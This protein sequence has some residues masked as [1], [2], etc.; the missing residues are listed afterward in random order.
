MD[1][2]VQL[3]M[4]KWPNVPHCYGWLGLDARGGWRMRDERSQELNLLGSKITNVALRD[5]INRNYQADNKG[6]YFFQNGPQRVYVELQST[7]Y[8]A[9]SDPELGWVL[10]TGVKLETC[11][12]IWMIEEGNLVLQSGAVLA[13]IDDRDLSEALSCVYLNNRKASD[14]QLLN[15]SQNAQSLHPDSLSF[16]FEKRKTRLALTNLADLA[17]QY[18][19]VTHPVSYNAMV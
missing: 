1:K 18:A 3:A 12:A 10:H 6:R 19:F 9:H 14:E 8:I 5:F 16:L 11:D 13:K 2:Q 15:L 7:P 17:K 4:A